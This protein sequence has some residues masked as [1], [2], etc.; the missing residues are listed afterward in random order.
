MQSRRL[1]TLV[2]SILY[3][4]RKLPYPARSA[5]KKVWW[6]PRVAR[7]HETS[8][9]SSQNSVIILCFRPRCLP[10]RKLSRVTL[11]SQPPRLCVL[12]AMRVLRPKLETLGK[13]CWFAVGLRVWFSLLLCMNKRAPSLHGPW[14]HLG[15]EST[16]RRMKLRS[17]TVTR[18]A[19]GREDSQDGDAGQPVGLLTPALKDL[20]P[21]CV[22]LAQPPT[23]RT[24]N[25]NADKSTFYCGKK[26]AYSS[27]LEDPGHLER[28]SPSQGTR[29][30][31]LPL[32]GPYWSAFSL[33]REPPGRYLEAPRSR[34]IPVGGLSFSLPTEVQPCS[35]T[36]SAGELSRGSGTSQVST[37]DAHH[38]SRVSHKHASRLVR[39]PEV[40]TT[41]LRVY[42]ACSTPAAEFSPVQGHLLL[43]WSEWACRNVTG[44]LGTYVISSSWSC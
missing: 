28:L 9:S 6:T 8:S 12:L 19:D 14:R 29:R 38:R 5:S 4:T 40:V 21:A 24:P 26:P 20:P 18:R 31:K 3:L 44:N 27:S 16:Q 34:V 41:K 23:H 13:G 7:P 32:Q 11:I 1:L 42:S 15:P 17:P 2:R 37:P 33:A 39:T 25:D 36:G 30:P 10:V 35:V 43:Q 22:A